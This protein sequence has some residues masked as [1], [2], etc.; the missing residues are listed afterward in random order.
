MMA[1]RAYPLQ[2]RGKRLSE[3]IK[4]Q[5]AEDAAVFPMLLSLYGTFD[6]DACTCL[7]I[8][9]ADNAQ[10]ARAH[11]LSLF[12]RPWRGLRQAQEVWWTWMGG[13]EESFRV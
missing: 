3:G 1:S 12:Q 5:N 10:G 4:V 9:P 2:E 13:Q 6:L 7:P 8:L 11:C